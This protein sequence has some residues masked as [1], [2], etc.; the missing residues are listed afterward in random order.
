MSR[1]TDY[2]TEV[3]KNTKALWNSLQALKGLQA[4][5]T[6]QDYG[7][8]MTDPI[9]GHEGYTNVMVGAVLF[10]TTDAIDDLLN[11]G[12]ATNVTALL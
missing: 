1:H 9:P 12:H 4:E 6:A 7:S 11:T 10:A 3:R 8:T 5:W 2:V